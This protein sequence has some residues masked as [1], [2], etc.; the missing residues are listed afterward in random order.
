[1]GR[2]P[3]G[4][5]DRQVAT[6][7]TQVMPHTHKTIS[8]YHHVCLLFVWIAVDGWG[9][10]TSC[11][12]WWCAKNYMCCIALCY[13]RLGSNL[14]CFF[15]WWYWRHIQI[16]CKCIC[17]KTKPLNL[18]FYR[19]SR[20]CPGWICCSS[21]TLVGVARI[22]CS[23]VNNAETAGHPGSVFHEWHSDSNL[24]LPVSIL[25]M[26]HQTCNF[27]VVIILHNT[28]F[29]CIFYSYNLFGDI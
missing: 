7:W 15:K 10:Q 22:Y 17:H 27:V 3:A 29:I 26:F 25:L 20:R 18:P 1:V 5:T 24:Q 4:R 2:Q 28:L 19:N 14:L 12:T 16:L 9:F 21:M 6:G 8:P 13:Y 11:T 23:G